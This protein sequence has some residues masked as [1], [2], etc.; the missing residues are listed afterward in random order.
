MSYNV[1]K[2]SYQTPVATVEWLSE[3]YIARDGGVSMTGNLNAGVNK[4]INVTDP[5]SNDSDRYGCS[6]YFGN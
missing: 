1:K 3:N 6:L 5:Q 4:V 2:P